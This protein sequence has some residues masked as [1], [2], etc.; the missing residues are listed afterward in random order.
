MN[1]A[2]IMLIPDGSY[3]AAR[4]KT[5]DHHLTVAFYGPITSDMRKSQ[6]SMRKAVEGVARSVSGPIK[7]KANGVG[8]F[9]AGSDGI[10][11]VDLIDG[12]GT[13]RTRTD[14]EFINSL[15]W[16][17]DYTHGF[18]PHITREFVPTESGGVS[19]SM[20][21]NL[22]FTFVALGLWFGD[23]RYEVGL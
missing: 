12:I 13:F 11:I 16:P 4:P 23:E 2:C 15:F 10:A 14:V 7:A 20:I 18:T 3:K 5:K 17:I 22:E 6:A 21:D 8:M 1:T 19:A 9:N